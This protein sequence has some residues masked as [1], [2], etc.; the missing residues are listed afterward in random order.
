[1]R[2][3]ANAAPANTADDL[4]L[5]NELVFAVISYVF[6]GLTS[7][8]LLLA[9]ETS[10]WLRSFARQHESLALP[11]TH[12]YRYETPGCLDCLRKT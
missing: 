6:I 11:G 1:M 8:A 10:C 4:Y 12:R 3:T 5:G 9:P 7:T 2:I